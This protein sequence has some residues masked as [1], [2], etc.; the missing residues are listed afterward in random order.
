MFQHIKKKLALRKGCYET[1]DPKPMAIPVSMRTPETSDQRMMKMLANAR[2]LA[3]MEG[4][5]TFEEANDF[6]CPDEW[7]PLP[8]SNHEY[9]EEIERSDREIIG[10]PPG[11][12]RNFL[13]EKPDRAPNNRSP[14]KKAGGNG[15]AKRPASPPP[16]DESDQDE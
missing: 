3:A 10:N 12:N 2:A 13:E 15:G 1:P 14:S 6:E 5:E 7:D 9:G 4:A 16:A 11:R 8:A